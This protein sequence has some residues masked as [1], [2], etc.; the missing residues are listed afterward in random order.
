M[1]DTICLLREF[2]GYRVRWSVGDQ[3]PAWLTGLKCWKH[4]SLGQ[5]DLGSDLTSA[6]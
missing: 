5:A 1:W 4:S 3:R 6:T 2:P